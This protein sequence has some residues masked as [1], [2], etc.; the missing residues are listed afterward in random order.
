MKRVSDLGNDNHEILN[1][2]TLSRLGRICKQSGSRDSGHIDC[3][4]MKLP[5]DN[6]IIRVV[7]DGNVDA[8]GRIVR[9]YQKPIY[10]LMYRASRSEHL[11][12]EMTQEVFTRAY[13]KLHR[14]DPGRRFYSWL[15][16]IGANLARDYLRRVGR[17]LLFSEAE[18]DG[19]ALADDR[20]SHAAAFEQ[21]NELSH[22]MRQL[23]NLPFDYREALILRYREELPMKEV[24][25]ALA[26]STSG[27]KMR[28]HRALKHLRAMLAANGRVGSPEIEKAGK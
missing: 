8:Y 16:A 23:D 18:I 24:A 21:Q 15:F 25:R 6:E 20:L 14:F 13:E 4:S 9:K 2:V 5:E 11:S 12:M 7:L 19:N 3:R 10:N 22:I 1:V 28:V 26:L 27:A 17:E